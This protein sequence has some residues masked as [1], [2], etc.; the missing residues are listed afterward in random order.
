[1]RSESG[2]IEIAHL[3]FLKGKLSFG[4]PAIELFR[5]SLESRAKGHEIASGARN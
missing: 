4:F 1:M 5:I 3:A 2:E